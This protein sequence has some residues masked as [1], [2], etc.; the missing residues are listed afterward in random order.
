M[1]N[2]INLIRSEKKH[3]SDNTV[4]QY[5]SIIK[6]LLI[7]GFNIDEDNLNMYYDNLKL[8][9]YDKNLIEKYID[10]LNK[11]SWKVKQ[12][13]TIMTLVDSYAKNKELSEYW[14]DKYNYYQNKAEID[15]LDKSKQIEKIVS[16]QDYSILLKHLILDSKHQEY[17]IFL[18]LWHIPLRNEI[19][20]IRY[21]KHSTFNNLTEKEIYNNNYL[22]VD[23]NNIQ[24]YRTNFKTFKR[25]GPILLNIEDVHLIN[26]LR[27]YIKSTDINENEFLF[28]K[29]KDYKNGNH[30]KCISNNYL[31]NCLAN[32]S[33]NIINVVLTETNIFKSSL[34]HNLNILSTDTEKRRFL[35]KMQ[36]QRGT[37]IY[38]IVNTY[39][40][41]IDG[42]DYKYLYVDYNNQWSTIYDRYKFK[43]NISFI[44][45]NL[46]FYNIQQYSEQLLC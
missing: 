9:I 45:G 11:N 40:I 29:K 36:K 18:M 13:V 20:N 34:L 8:W 30:K 37:H 32:I 44:L 19:A 21:I 42:T 25:C 26:T 5:L 12:V 2:I 35:I 23:D 27:D 10:S 15:Y 14:F 24:L 7:K 28:V 43:Q 33:K 16:Y 38:N 22:I 6:N 4:N 41:S 39:I 3:L 46:H 1:D 17:L 31:A